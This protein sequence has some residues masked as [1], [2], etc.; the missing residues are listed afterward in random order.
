[1]TERNVVLVGG[2]ITKFAA[3]VPDARRGLTDTHAGT[4]THCV[5]NIFKRRDQVIVQK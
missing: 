5:V 3:Q 2:G 1:M 4:G